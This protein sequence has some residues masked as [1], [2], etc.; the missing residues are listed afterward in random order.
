MWAHQSFLNKLNPWG[1][2]ASRLAKDPFNEPS[3]LVTSQSPL[4]LS[5]TVQRQLAVRSNNIIQ[6]QSLVRKKTSSIVAIKFGPQWSNLLL[7]VTFGPITPFSSFGTLLNLAACLFF[8]FP[9]TSPVEIKFG[10]PTLHHHMLASAETAK[11]VRRCLLD[12]T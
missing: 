5:S 6:Y 8:L 7:E 10:E 3:D 9:P 12:D 1:P 2:I 11:F 4:T